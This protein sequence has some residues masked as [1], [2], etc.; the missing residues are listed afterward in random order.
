M[1]KEEKALEY[2][3]NI[4]GDYFYEMYPDPAVTDSLGEISQKDYLAGYEQAIEDSCATEM[5]EMLERIFQ[6]ESD[7]GLRIY[8]K[9]LI[10][11]V[12]II[13]K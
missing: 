4:W 10:E 7:L 11:K 5:L 6:T 13:N 12:N 2:S 9:S 3:K 8:L 1:N